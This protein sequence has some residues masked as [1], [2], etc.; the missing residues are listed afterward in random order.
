MPGKEPWAQDDQARQLAWWR[1]ELGEK[2]LGSRSLTLPSSDAK[3]KLSG[4]Q[5]GTGQGKGTPQRSF[6]TWQPSRTPTLM[7]VKRMGLD[8]RKPC[9]GSRTADGT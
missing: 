8:R 2:T 7:G 3:D 5:D 4:E 6:V 9:P 1:A